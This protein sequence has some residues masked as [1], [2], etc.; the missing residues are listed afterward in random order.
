MT[1]A[2]P[3]TPPRSQIRKLFPEKWFGTFGS[4]MAV[5]GTV[6]SAAAIISLIQH[7]AEIEVVAIPALALSYYRGLIQGCVGWIPALVGWEWQQWALDLLAVSSCVGGAAIRAIKASGYHQ[8]IQFSRAIWLSIPLLLG[9]LVGPALV[10]FVHWF[11][12]SQIDASKKYCDEWTAKLSALRSSNPQQDLSH[13]E[14]T[15]AE[16]RGFIDGYAEFL[17]IQKLFGL[18]LLLVLVAT[19]IF[20]ILNGLAPQ[21]AAGGGA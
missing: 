12:L 3:I 1:S 13:I 5:F 8:G 9:W 14:K 19:L 17:H 21:L 15:L 16:H 18:A 4:A 20:F 2:N 11:S 7:R 6:T 10:A